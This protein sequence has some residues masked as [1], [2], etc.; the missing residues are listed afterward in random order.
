V[1]A[2]RSG[3]QRPGKKQGAGGGG[4]GG[5]GGRGAGG[6]GGASRNGFV[7]PFVGKALDGPGEGEEGPYSAGVLELLAGGQRAAVWA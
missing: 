6:G 4:G 7:P 5:G 3:L 2:P 1:Q